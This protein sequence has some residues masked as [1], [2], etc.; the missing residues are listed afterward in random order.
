[1]KN[2]K[3]APLVFLLVI[4]VGFT[5]CK[6]PENHIFYDRN[7]VDEIK[8]AREAMGFFMYSNLIPGTQIAIYKQG[9]MI[10]SEGFGLASKDLNVPVSRETKFRIGDVTEV[11]TSLAYRMMVENGTLHPDSSIQNYLPDFPTKESKITLEQL[12]QNTSGIREENSAGD[13]NLMYNI[14]LQMGLDKFKDDALLFMPGFL[15]TNSVYDYNLL[16]A[17]ME[18]ATGQNF[19]T[20]IKEL[21][22][23][24]LQLYYTLMDNPFTTIEGRTDFYDINI[25]GTPINAITIDHRSNEPSLGLLSTAEDLAKFGNAILHS[26]VI[27]DKIREELFTPFQLKAG[28]TAEKTN[29]WKLFKDNWGRKFYA[30]IG[31]VNGGGASLLVFPDDDLVVAITINLT[32]NILELPDYKIASLFLPKTEA[33]IEYEQKQK[34]KETTESKGKIE[35][36]KE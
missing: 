8:Q 16:G 3:L 14:N 12:A 17:I 33:Q 20:I 29:S 25:V 28:F 15:Q 18:N 27:S 31:N 19:G 11:Y 24:T 21:V 35:E 1:M 36:T 34:E 5:H 13:R 6:K 32:L 4:I 30:S 9:K 10:Y 7:Y 26:P 2:K 23:D 22:T